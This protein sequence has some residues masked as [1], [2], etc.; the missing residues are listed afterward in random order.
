[1]K[2]KCA[3]ISVCTLSFSVPLAAA[4]Q[5]IAAERPPQ[6][7]PD[8][9]VLEKGIKEKLESANLEARAPSPS[10]ASPSR[11]YLKLVPARSF[12][13]GAHLLQ[14]AAEYRE[15]ARTCCTRRTPHPPVA[16]TVKPRSPRSD[17]LPPINWRFRL[18]KPKGF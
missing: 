13:H 11:S 5:S 16:A 8:T 1:M 6:T 4:D 14:R 9:T 7:S 10:K 3:V 12:R 15:L 2:L 17:A 18:R